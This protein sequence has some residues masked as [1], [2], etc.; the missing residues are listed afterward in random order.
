MLLDNELMIDSRLS[1]PI[2]FIVFNRPQVTERVFS[3]IRKVKPKHL[4]IIGDGPRESIISDAENCRLVRDIVSQ[5]DWDCQT[6]T[7]FSSVNLGCKKRITTG[8]SWVFENVPEAIIL[9]DDCL[10]EPSFFEFCELML[11]RYRDNKSVGIISGDNFS[12]LSFPMTASYYFSRYAHIWGWACWRRTWEKYSSEIEF[13]PSF[14]DSAQFNRLVF[15]SSEK[16]YWSSIFERVYRGLIDTWDYQLTLSMWRFNFVSVVPAVNLIKNIGFG[17]DAT[18]TKSNSPLSNITTHPMK[19][20][21]VHPRDIQ[22]DNFFD[23]IESKKMYQPFF[24]KLLAKKILSLF[25]RR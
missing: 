20:P 2:V 21:L 10:P 25:L 16:A 19:F 11:D 15:N 9:E 8:L 5:V 22:V 12:S 24:L 13:W 7:N 14:K 4:L 23:E 17:Q 3:E 18:H 6:L 1:T